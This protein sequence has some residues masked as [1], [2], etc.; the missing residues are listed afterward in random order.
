MGIL[1]MDHFE[2][3]DRN[4]IREYYSTRTGANGELVRIGL[5]LSA[6][7]RG[8]VVLSTPGLNLMCRPPVTIT[9]I[10]GGH[11]VEREYKP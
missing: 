3:Y 9:R 8:S 11:K 6:D 5:P 1:F 4:G 2:R 7:E 10:E